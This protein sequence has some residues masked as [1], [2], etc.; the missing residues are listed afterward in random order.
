MFIDTHGGCIRKPA[1]VA[2]Q[3]VL[4][5]WQHLGGRGGKRWVVV[6]SERV[7]VLS[8]KTSRGMRAISLNPFQ[9]LSFYNHINC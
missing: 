4:K 9:L 5:A 2:K 6:K 1:G 7:Q 3:Q 8:E